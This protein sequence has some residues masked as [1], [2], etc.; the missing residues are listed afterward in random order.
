[1]SSPPTPPI[2]ISVRYLGPIFELDGELSK[3]KQNL[4]FARNGTGKSFLSR[5]YRCLDNGKQNGDLSK[6]GLDLVSDESPNTKGIFSVSRGTS[7]LGSLSLERE[8]ESSTAALTDT[9]FHVFSEDFIDEEL[10]ERKYD[11]NGEVD[12]QIAIDGGNIDLKDAQTSLSISEA[13]AF[14]KRD[15]LVKRFESEKKTELSDKAS[16]NK[17]LSEYKALNFEALYEGAVEK[18]SIPTSSSSQLLS[19]LDKLKS[20]PAEPIYPNQIQML[21]LVGLDK[22]AFVDALKRITSPSTVSEQVKQKIDLNRNFFDEGIRLFEIREDKNCPFCE[23]KIEA[24]ATKSVIDAYVQYFEAEEEKHKE[25]L[26]GY[27]RALVEFEKAVSESTIV[28]ASQASKY[29]A[30]KTYLPAHKDTSLESFLEPQEVLLA[31]IEEVK[32]SIQKKADDLKTVLSTPLSKLEESIA[33]FNEVVEIR[34]KKSDDLSKAIAGAD[35][36]RKNTQRKLCTVFGKEFIIEKWND[37]LTLRQAIKD[38]DLKKAKLK[39]KEESSPTSSAKNRVANTFEML[40]LHFF[41]NK[42]IFDKDNFLLKRG[43][44]EM[45]RGS[46]RT[47]SDGEKTAIAFCYFIACIHRKVGANSDYENIF[48]VFDD[49]VTSMSYDYVFAIAQTLKNLTVSKTGQVSVNPSDIEKANCFR[50][51]LLILTH[52]SYFFNIS[53]TNRVIRENAT[54]A[55]QGGQFKHSLAPLKDYI[56]PFQEQLKDVYLVSEGQAPDHR[57]A[58]C[59]RSVLEAVGRFCRPDKTDSLTNFVKFIAAESELGI[60]AVMINNLCHGTYYDETPTP[61]DISLACKETIAVVELYAFGQVENIRKS[62]GVI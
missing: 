28:L 15:A 9:I 33:S 26:R 43:Q 32:A 37:V 51:E 62:I 3:N 21:D 14:T 25:E 50:P 24:D 42:Y 40:L 30:M 61:S 27:Y 17:Q 18:P 44:N 23:Q 53:I 45:P 2:S 11:I 35:N 38:V 39:Q 52:S 10:R 31:A 57:T 34:N 60:Q 8:K 5:A 49:P 54:F 16:I 20:I 47:L 46:H 13:D 22:V 41:G 48:L 4:I 1:M 56:A 55:L 59:V 36:E 6:S 19:D 7:P 58:N 12:N 29:D